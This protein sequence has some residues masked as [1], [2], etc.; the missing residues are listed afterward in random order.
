MDMLAALYAYAQWVTALC[1][2]ATITA[3]AAVL[4]MRAIG[5]G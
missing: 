1:T 4:A 3:A 5:D 2:L